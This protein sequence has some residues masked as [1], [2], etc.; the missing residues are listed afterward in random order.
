MKCCPQWAALHQRHERSVGH[1]NRN[2][3]LLSLQ[4]LTVAQGLWD[5]F[6]RQ[7]S[8]LTLTALLSSSC[9]TSIQSPIKGIYDN[10]SENSFWV[11]KVFP[12]FPNSLKRRVWLEAHTERTNPSKRILELSKHTLK[13]TTVH[14]VL[15]PLLHAWKRSAAA[16]WDPAEFV[17][18][19]CLWG[20][21]SPLWT[22]A[23]VGSLWDQSG[24]ESRGMAEIQSNHSRCSAFVIN[25]DGRPK[26]QYFPLR[27]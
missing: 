8:Q 16:S 19:Q 11:P 23:A 7:S 27:H 18:R 1:N 13:W 15:L 20:D 4:P 26:R 9:L 21:F 12:N 10:F 17:K 6:N 2:T 24:G 25:K 5:C 3:G 14:F 22:C